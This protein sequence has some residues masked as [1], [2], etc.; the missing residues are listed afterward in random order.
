ML[1]S[2][3]FKTKTF[4]DNQIDPYIP[5]W[6]A[7]ETLAILYEELLYLNFVNQDFN[8]YF[9]KYGDVVN[10]RR[11]RELEGKRK[12]KGDPVVAQDVIAD[13]VPIRLDQWCYTSFIIDDIEE[14][15]SMKKLSDEY[16]RPAATSLARMVDR[17]IAGQYP[18]FLPNVAGKLNGITTS[19]IK[20]YV[21]DMRQVLD[22]TKAPQEGRNLILTSKTEGD[23]LRPEWFTS[24]DK[25]GDSGTALRT[26][27]LGQKLGF[28]FFKSLNAPNITVGNTIRTFQINNAA[29]YDVGATALTVDTGTGEITPG[30]WV[31]IDGIPYQVASRTGTAPTTAV[32][33]SYG[34]RRAVADNAPVVVYTPGAVNNGGGYAQYYNKIITVDGFTVAPRV[35]QLVSF[36]SDTTNVYAIIDVDGL[37]GITLDRSLE[38]AI[39][40]DATVNIGPAGAYNMAVQRNAITVAL[41]GLEPVRPGAGAISTSTNDGRM[42]MRVT[43][44]YDPV[45]QRHRWTF[46]FLAGIQ[47][48][49]KNLGG[50]LLG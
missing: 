25:V 37:T 24:A 14:T 50:V 48:L 47:V 17:M 12:V 36:G 21:I 9:N 33:L 19:N 15:M 27:S 42:P 30:T 22:D 16:A 34:L 43:I 29:G 6:W 26:A 1:L 44:S 10:T 46:D 18:R 45:Y 13:N 41:R 8:K 31:Q 40:D 4:F 20:D 38:A 28:D 3:R 5:E 32:A 49:D 23:M 11:P 2:K 39:A 7:Q 35:G